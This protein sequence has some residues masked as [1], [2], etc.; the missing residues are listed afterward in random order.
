MTTE[1]NELIAAGDEF[2][3]RLEEADMLPV[4]SFDMWARDH[5]REIVT[6]LETAE[7]EING[8]G[9]W[10]ELCEGHERA[11]NA[12]PTEFQV[13]GL[14]STLEAAEHNIEAQT[15]EIAE[16]S[17]QLTETR[18][19]LNAALAGVVVLQEV[20]A[21]VVTAWKGGYTVEYVLPELDDAL[22]LTM[23]M[24]SNLRII[25][26]GR[27]AIAEARSKER[28]AAKA[29]CQLIASTGGSATHCVYAI[30]ALP[31][32]EIL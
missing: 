17:K 3:S 5:W 25:D 13:S 18:K 15:V 1:T 32:K 29:A 11:L 7:R 26:A 24:P 10:R 30:Q 9:G 21:R 8:T 6:A 12:A 19:Q 22:Q 31:T 28:E 14:R 2:H 20:A 16:T 27:M 4:T 23:R